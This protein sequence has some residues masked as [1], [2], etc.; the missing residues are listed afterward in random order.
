MDAVLLGG[1]AGENV[2]FGCTDEAAENF[3][4]DATNLDGAPTGSELYSTYP[5]SCVYADILGCTDE[6]AENYNPGATTDDGSCVYL[7]D[8]PGDD[9][10]PGTNWCKSIWYD[11]PV[12]NWPSIGGEGELILDGEEVL[13]SPGYSCFPDNTVYY[14]FNNPDASLT[15][16][17]LILHFEHDS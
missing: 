6:E 15:N 9:E 7:P 1:L 11:I 2:I 12:G 4:P 3:N 13:Y 10:V 17:A 8:W 16:K 5:N 14:D